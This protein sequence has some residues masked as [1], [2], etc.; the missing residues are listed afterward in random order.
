M[1]AGEQQVD[2]LHGLGEGEAP[3]LVEAERLGAVAGQVLLEVPPLLLQPLDR[4]RLHLGPGLPR[5]LQARDDPR[6]PFAGAEARVQHKGDVEL[7]DEEA[8]ARDPLAVGVVEPAG[9]G[10][11]EVALWVAAVEATD[12][13]RPHG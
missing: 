3:A 2:E 7:V 8:G 9:E 4:F 6:Q 13:V 1:A 12:E 11:A 10:R 5:P